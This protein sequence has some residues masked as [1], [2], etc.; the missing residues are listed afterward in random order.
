MGE[1]LK[2]LPSFLSA[3]ASIAAAITAIVALKITRESKFLATR[4]ALAT[5]HSSASLQLTHAVEELKPNIFKISQF[6]YS[7]LVN[8]A[9]EIQKYDNCSVVGEDPRPLRHVLFD[10]AEMLTSHA[11]A[12]TN[13]SGYL[14]NVMFEIV[15]SGGPIPS[16]GEFEEL[17][18]QADHC[19]SSFESVFGQPSPKEKISDAKAFR[20]SFF[21][22]HARVSPH[23]WSE[24][25][26]RAWS[27]NGRLAQLEK[28]LIS[29]RPEFERVKRSLLIEESKLANTVFPL[30]QNGQLFSKFRSLKKVLNTLLIDCDLDKLSFYRNSSA[31]D[32]ALELVLY[33]FG[34]MELLS[35]LEDDIC[36]IQE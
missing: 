5:H 28:M 13:G 11:Q 12:A 23:E 2:I 19:C 7:S 16:E 35:Q 17:L 4:S 15:R 6:A 24:T 20:W 3:G 9:K 1:W 8:W 31:D 33:T 18:K 14:H 34:A 25:W 30:E 29:F 21:Q 10:T 27:D 32:D 22:C 26:N 36:S